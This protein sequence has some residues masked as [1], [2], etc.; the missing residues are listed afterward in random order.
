MISWSHAVRS[1][2]FLAAL[3]VGYNEEITKALPIL[4]AALILLRFRGIKL[5][6]RMWMFLGTIRAS[7][8][9]SWRRGCTP[10]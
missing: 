6:V 8:S 2:N 5:S 9:A 10:R 7:P 3:A 4:L 1:G